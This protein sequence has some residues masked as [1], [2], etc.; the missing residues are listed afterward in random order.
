M[1]NRSAGKSYINTYTFTMAS[2]LFYALLK[3]ISALGLKKKYIENL[4]KWKR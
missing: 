4:I 2:A 1:L 3:L